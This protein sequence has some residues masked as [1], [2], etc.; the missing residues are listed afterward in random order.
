MALV[1]KTTAQFV[2]DVET[3]YCELV[4]AALSKPGDSTRVVMVVRTANGNKEV[5]DVG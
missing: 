1:T 2:S 3:G 5:W 4:M